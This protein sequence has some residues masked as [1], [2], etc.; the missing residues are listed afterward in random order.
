[1]YTK[2]VIETTEEIHA[3]VSC[4][5]SEENYQTTVSLRLRPAYEFQIPKGLKNNKCWNVCTSDNSHLGILVQF[6]VGHCFRAYLYP[7]Y[8]SDIKYYESRPDV[9]TLEKA[10]VQFVVFHNKDYKPVK[11]TTRETTKT[12]VTR[13]TPVMSNADKLLIN[14][15]LKNN[16]T[17]L[18][19]GTRLSPEHR[20]IYPDF[21]KID[22]PITVREL[23]KELSKVSDEATFVIEDNTEYY[24]ACIS[25]YLDDVIPGINTL[26]EQERQYLEL[27]I[28]E[29]TER[30]KQGKKTLKEQKTKE[31]RELYEKLKKKYG[32]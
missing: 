28:R 10:L 9:D 23:K 18:E 5:Y 29:Q 24:N 26:T 17:T 25:V 32:R 6:N 20:R 4:T 21:I 12:V 14:L 11:V 16:I 31:E 13:E 2:P 30:V 15:A 27:K 3:E 19:D 7:G 8:S 22:Q 1:M